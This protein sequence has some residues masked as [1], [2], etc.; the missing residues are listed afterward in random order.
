MDNII[1]VIIIFI[2]WVICNTIVRKL[3]L[4]NAY[5]EIIISAIKYRKTLIFD[6]IAIIIFT[7]LDMTFFTWIGIIYYILISIIEGS[8]LIISLITNLDFYFKE[9]IFEKE[10]WLLVLSKLLNEIASVMA[11]ISLFSLL[12]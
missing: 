9:H 5:Q 3:L 7:F 2:F 12:K 4:E 1:Y 8:L 6:I 11:V 10:M